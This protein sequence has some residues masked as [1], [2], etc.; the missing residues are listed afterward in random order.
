MFI[1]LQ[2]KTMR[3]KKHEESESRMKRINFA[4]ATCFE[5]FIYFHRDVRLRR[6]T[7]SLENG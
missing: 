7:Y 5:R 2:E 1:S 4:S 6:G 3:G